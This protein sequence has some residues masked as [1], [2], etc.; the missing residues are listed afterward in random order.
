[1]RK[2]Q[3]LAALLGGALSYLE[4]C[5]GVCEV[6]LCSQPP[7]TAAAIQSW[8]SK[9]LAIIAASSASP[10]ITS[11]TASPNCTP[12]SSTFA[13]PP[14]PLKGLFGS[15]SNH[16]ISQCRWMPQDLAGLYSMTD[17]LS[18]QWSVRFGS[19]PE[20]A[21]KRRDLQQLL[22]QE[23]LD[24]SLHHSK[25]APILPALHTSS[26][27]RRPTAKSVSVFQHVV[28]RMHQR[29]PHP[30]QYGS[31]IRVEHGTHSRRRFPRFFRLMV[32]HLGVLGWHM[33]MTETGMG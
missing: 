28:P 30:L 13:P 18:V 17:G 33:G 21:M 5:P 4:S 12:P 25:E 26:T 19:D 8:E 6:K 11:P 22:H 24:G 9:N 3:A 15:T 1:M 10:V 7:V 31:R 2:H 23:K 14:P 32:V 16:P 29:Q 27:T 20:Q